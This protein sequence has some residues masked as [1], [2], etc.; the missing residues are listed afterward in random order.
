LLPYAPFSQFLETV[1]YAPL[2]K[3]VISFSS[4]PGSKLL[5]SLIIY[6]T[7]P[8][9]LSVALIA[10]IIALLKL[11]ILIES[12]LPKTDAKPFTE[13]ILFFNK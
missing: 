1:S 5:K 8:S 6:W 7:T 13:I 3:L 11:N 2:I 4:K 12:I 10:E 9:K